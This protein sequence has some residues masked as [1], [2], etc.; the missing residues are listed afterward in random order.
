MKSG[1][2]D[3]DKVIAYGQ[4]TWTDAFGPDGALQR[5]E[6]PLEYRDRAA[7]DKP[8]YLVIVVSASKYGDFFSGSDKSVVYLDD[9][10]LVYE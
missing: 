6:I 4:I 8:L 5:V 7:T 1:D 9:F 3:Y 2:E 10:E